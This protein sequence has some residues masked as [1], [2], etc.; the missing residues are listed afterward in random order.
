MIKYGNLR[1]EGFLFANSPR[2]QSITSRE[3]KQELEATNHITYLQSKVK[4]NVCSSVFSSLHSLHLYSS[5]FPY[6]GNGDAHTCLYLPMLLTK[7]RQLPPIDMARDQ[8]GISNFV[9]RLPSQMALA[10]VKLVTES[11]HHTIYLPIGAQ[12]ASIF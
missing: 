10:C 9:L 2:S 12:A 8:P 6:L 11:S 4:R 5:G 3:S 7:S 1:K